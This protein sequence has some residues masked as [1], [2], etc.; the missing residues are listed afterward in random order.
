V[1]DPDA[2]ATL[3]RGGW[4]HTGDEGVMDEEGFFTFLD[5]KKDVIRRRGENIASQQVEHV[6]LSHPKVGKT[7][8][9]GIASELGEEEVLALIVPLE[10]VTPEELAAY[11]AERL[12]AFKVP[13]WYRFVD[14]LPTTPTGRVKKAVLKA[15]TNLAEGAVKINVTTVTRDTP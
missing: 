1:D 10:P 11:C 14:E 2:T 13:E 5:R 8:V 15:R 6:L 9:L 3:W 7:A 4:L 12:A